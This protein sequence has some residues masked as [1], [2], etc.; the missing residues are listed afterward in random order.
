M[1]NK[2]KSYPVSNRQKE[3]LVE[4]ISA[5]REMYTGKLNQSY[6]RQNMIANWV[7]LT[8]ILNSVP[9]GPSKD[10]KQWRKVKIINKYLPIYV[11]GCR[12]TFWHTYKQ[13]M[14]FI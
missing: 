1:E 4:F 10:W 5:R 12:K 11:S 13:N 14:L 6:T 9:E 7:E 3:M 8:N 2:Q